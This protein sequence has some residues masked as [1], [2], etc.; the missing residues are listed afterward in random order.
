MWTQWIREKTLLPRP[1]LISDKK[2]YTVYQIFRMLL[3]L[4]TSHKA[5]LPN[6]DAF[7]KNINFRENSARAPV[8]I[9]R[10]LTAPAVYTLSRPPMISQ[11][12]PLCLGEEADLFC[13][14]KLLPVSHFSFFL[15][16]LPQDLLFFSRVCGAA[17]TDAFSL[18]SSSSFSTRSPQ[19]REKKA[20][21]LFD[22]KISPSPRPAAFSSYVCARGGL[23]P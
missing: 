4:H 1:K 11:S 22:P 9:Y 15:P 10:P 20:F 13:G 3:F 5:A 6:I 8:K 17:T 21:F 16:P 14:G 19:K 12:M 2:A 7:V 23:E 18:S